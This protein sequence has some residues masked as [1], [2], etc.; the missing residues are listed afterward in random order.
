MKVI[1]YAKH[2]G[3]E[4]DLIFESVADLLNDRLTDAVGVYGCDLHN[5]IFNE[6]PAFIYTNKAE[7]AV[8]SVGVWLSLIHI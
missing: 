1:D 5:H 2:K 7:S 8:D 3:M 4:E 6:D